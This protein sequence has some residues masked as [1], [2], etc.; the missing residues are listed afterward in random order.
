[1]KLITNVFYVS[2]LI[3]CLYTLVY[4]SLPGL[5]ASSSASL[6]ATHLQVQDVEAVL[7]VERKIDSFMADKLFRQ[8]TIDET[9]YAASLVD[10]G[11]IDTSLGYHYSQIGIV[12]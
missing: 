7:R 5:P 12:E 8:P 1:M 11:G 10:M 3:K 9:I 4:F 2:H 6:A